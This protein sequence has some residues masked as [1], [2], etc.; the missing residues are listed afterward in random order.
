[1]APQPRLPS[2][3]P[4]V[5]EDIVAIAKAEELTIVDAAIDGDIDTSDLSTFLEY[6]RDADADLDPGLVQIVRLV[7]PLLAERDK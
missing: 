7:K 6:A 2:D 4:P 5:C 3:S 1:M